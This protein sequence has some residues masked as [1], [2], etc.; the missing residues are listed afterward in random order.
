MAIQDF[1]K[2]V[3]YVMIVGLFGGRLGKKRSW[4]SGAREYLGEAVKLL[5]V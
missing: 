5:A 1:A 3:I 2:N 4:N